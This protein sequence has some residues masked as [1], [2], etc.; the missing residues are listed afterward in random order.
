VILAARPA[1][2]LSLLLPLGCVVEPTEVGSDDRAIVGGAENTTDDAT[3]ALVGHVGEAT[4]VCSGVLIGARTVLTSAHCVWD[5]EAIEVFF[6]TDIYDPD[7]VIETIDATGWLAH[8]EWQTT[9]SNLFDLHF[10][11]GLVT[12]GS[13]APV[14]PVLFNRVP[15]EDTM[16]GQAVRLIGFGDTYDGA[17]NSGIRRSASTE[18]R[19]FDDWWTTAGSS[20]ANTCVG[21]SGGPQLMQVAGTEVVFG[22]TSFGTA[23]PEKEI[24]RYDTIAARTDIAAVDFIDTY[25]VAND[26][27]G[28]CGEDGACPIEC[29]TPEQDP[30]CA[31][32]CIVD[33]KCEPG[34]GELD[35]ECAEPAPTPGP[36]PAQPTEEG[37]G[38]SAAAP[39]Q[40]TPLWWLSVLALLALPRRRRQRT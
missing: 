28:P 33:G 4:Y 1:L 19:A 30:D 10:D 7:T 20:N 11:L 38:C 12:L 40:T 3:V 23:P 26:V 16:L 8:P 27:P 37:G 15:L 21:D 6:A 34:C 24:C 5:R 13:D 35:P 32:L 14:A 31:D 25:L 18:L 2:V 29:A 9:S 36:A 22:L 17:F 39:S